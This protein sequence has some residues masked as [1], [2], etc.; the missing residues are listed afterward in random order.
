VRNTD[1]YKLDD[2]LARLQRDLP[3]GSGMKHYV[4]PAS[5]WMAGM[6]IPGAGG[7]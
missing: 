2:L 4:N 5:C 1:L 7:L 6:K 3:S